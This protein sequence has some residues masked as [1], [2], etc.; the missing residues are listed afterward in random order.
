M[1]SYSVFC[2]EQTG[3]YVLSH[4]YIIYYIFVF[5]ISIKTSTSSGLAATKCD[6]PP[7]QICCYGVQLERATK[8]T[9]TGNI[10]GNGPNTTYLCVVATANDCPDAQN[11]NIITTPPAPSSSLRPTTA[12]TTPPVVVE[13]EVPPPPVEEVEECT[14]AICDPTDADSCNCRPSLTCRNRGG[15][16]GFICSQVSR[17]GRTRLSNADGVGGA[18]GRSD[19]GQ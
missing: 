19:R 9:C 13:E 5:S 3:F 12:P 7:D 14:G 2:G 4:S 18:G 1:R 10:N 11:P 17:V 16:T 8:C 6:L 15:S